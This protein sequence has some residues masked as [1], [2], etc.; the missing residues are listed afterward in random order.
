MT[1]P[2]TRGN[3]TTGGREVETVAHFIIGDKLLPALVKKGVKH[4]MIVD[5]SPNG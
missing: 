5:E 2:N 4:L 1:T 3:V